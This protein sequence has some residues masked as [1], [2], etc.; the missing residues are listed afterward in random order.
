MD[1]PAR[2]RA[3]SRRWQLS[4]PVLSDASG[5]AVDALGI[6]HPKG[7]R[8]RDCAVPT[9]LLFDA[10]RRLVESYRAERTQER[11]APDDVLRWI[12]DPGTLSAT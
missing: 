6:R 11:L 5:L 12:D 4:F 7:H 8:G 1:D 9:V 2:A 3:A 10:G